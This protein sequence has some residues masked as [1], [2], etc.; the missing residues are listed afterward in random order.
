MSAVGVVA[1]RFRIEREL[2][3]GG[4]ASVYL[5][6][7]EE[8]GRLVAVKLMHEQLASDET[9]R[10]RFVREARLAARLSHPNV[11]SVFDAGTDGDGRPFIVMEYVDGTTVASLGVLPVDRAVEV[12]LQACAGLAHA[13]ALGLVH[14]DVKPHN[15]L[16]RVDGAVKVADFGIAR[17]AEEAGL[18]KTGTILGTAAYLAPEQSVG[19]E[20]TPA[21]DVYGLAAV[22]YACLAGRPPHPFTSPVE[23][24]KAQHEPVTPLRDL[25]P[26]VPPALERVLMESLASDPAARPGDAGELGRRIAEASGGDL[27]LAPTEPIARTAVLA[28]APTEPLRPARQRRRLAVPAL[29]AA[30]LAAIAGGL[31]ITLGGRAKPVPP[32]AAPHVAPIPTVGSAAEQAK[33]LAAWLRRYAR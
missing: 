23:L 31:A 16:V 5:A 6:R 27:E 15:L 8:L 1:G 26:A 32:P 33:N 14:R 4:M 9:F 17:A 11:V 21:T 19:G 29:A 22:V 20:V 12:A 30:A 2:G 25:A 18:T 24:V 10:R 7:D 28:P 3:F 13:H